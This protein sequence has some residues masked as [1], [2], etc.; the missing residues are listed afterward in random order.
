[1]YVGDLTAN[2]IEIIKGFGGSK[3]INEISEFFNIKNKST[4]NLR[5]K[6]DRKNIKYKF[7]R[8]QSARK[9]SYENIEDMLVQKKGVELECGK[10]YEI[11]DNT[12][13]QELD[14]S[15]YEGRI[16]KEYRCFYLGVS[17]TGYNFTI[18]KYPNCYDIKEI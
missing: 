11:I 16:I 15:R 4:E 2:D 10:R 9:K 14:F 8:K 5:K 17:D 18:H 1:M 3:T 6:L 12:P 13:Q 7:E